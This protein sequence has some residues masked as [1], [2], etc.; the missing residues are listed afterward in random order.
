MLSSSVSRCPAEM[1]VTVSN[2]F[3]DTRKCTEFRQVVVS[4]H[5]SKAGPIVKNGS[6][7]ICWIK[8]FGLLD[9]KSPIFRMAI[10]ICDQ[11]IESNRASPPF[12]PICG[13]EFASQSNVVF[14]ASDLFIQRKTLSLKHF[15]SVD[16]A[17]RGEFG[18]ITV[19]ELNQYAR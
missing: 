13:L 2:E 7:N 8:S 4:N 3:V 10:C 17:G 6:E 1:M 18:L 5:V 16:K 15:D 19:E 14:Q 9:K 11:C 12:Q